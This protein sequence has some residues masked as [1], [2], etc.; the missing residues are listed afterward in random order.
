MIMGSP[1]E[2]A[3]QG[4]E[5]SCLEAVFLTSFTID[6]EFFSCRMTRIASYVSNGMNYFH[7]I[8]I[9]HMELKT[10]NLLMDDQELMELH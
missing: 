9:V 3:R 6:E 10:A 2:N 8:N 5:N 1:L 7:R 4:P